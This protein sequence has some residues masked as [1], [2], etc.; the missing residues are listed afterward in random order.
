MYIE[1]IGSMNSA[2]PAAERPRVVPPAPVEA[3]AAAGAA[4]AAH[5]VDG[6]GLKKAL[7]AANRMVLSLGAS[8]EFSTDLDTGKTL[9]RVIDT[10]TNELIRQIPAEE[11][12]ALAR[13]LDT[14]QG[15]LIDQQA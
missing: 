6:G 1:S 9:V 15:L 13:A 11:M 12:L 7:E 2:A 4:A 5:A 10:S 3:P 14:L 8:L